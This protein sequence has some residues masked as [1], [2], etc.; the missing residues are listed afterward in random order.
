MTPKSVVPKETRTRTFFD[1]VGMVVPDEEVEARAVRCVE[2]VTDAKG[3]IIS[4]T[5]YMARE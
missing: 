2:H 1:Q 4:E 3:R 5:I